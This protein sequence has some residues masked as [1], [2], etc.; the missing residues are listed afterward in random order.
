MK[1]VQMLIQ[2]M[3][4]KKKFILLKGLCIDMSI[5]EQNVSIKLLD[6]RVVRY[7]SILLPFAPNLIERTFLCPKKMYLV[8]NMY[9]QVLM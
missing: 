1:Y 8:H 4:K 2:R 6:L 5:H 9:V 3:Q 7:H